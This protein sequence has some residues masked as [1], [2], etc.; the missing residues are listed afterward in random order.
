ML[1]VACA[2]SG[3]AGPLTVL[4]FFRATQRP[5][6]RSSVPAISSSSVAD[7]GAT[8]SS[9][10]AGTLMAPFSGSDFFGVFEPREFE[11][12]LLKGSSSSSL[13]SD[14]G[15]DEG[16]F[17]TGEAALLLFLGRI[18]V[19]SELGVG[20]SAVVVVGAAAGTPNARLLPSG[21]VLKTVTGRCVTISCATIF[22]VFTATL[23]VVVMG[24]ILAT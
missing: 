7:A 12:R 24:T 5:M 23:R 4:L 2:T 3:K 13:L 18:A 17:M 16:L 15:L 14:E 22:T 20:C 9:V 21:T 11:L 8:S 1:V 6:G 10:V 19:A